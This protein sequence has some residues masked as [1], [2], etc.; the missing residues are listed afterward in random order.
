MTEALEFTTAARG[1]EPIPFKIDGEEFTF[2]PPKQALMVMPYIDGDE[3]FLR[4]QVKWL[5]TGLTDEA[6]AR[7]RERLADPEDRFD[8]PDLTKLIRALDQAVA[9]RPTT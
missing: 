3:D 7:I 1:A 5:W 2:T 8:T 4:Q 6:E 9:G